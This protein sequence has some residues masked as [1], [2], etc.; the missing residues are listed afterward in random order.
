MRKLDLINENARRSKFVGAAALGAISAIGGIVGK[1][2]E[3]RSNKMQAKAI[4]QQRIADAEKAKQQ[5]KLIKII[6]IAVVVIATI[7]IAMRR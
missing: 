6:L 1:G 2:L 7:I 3:S 4:E 5:E